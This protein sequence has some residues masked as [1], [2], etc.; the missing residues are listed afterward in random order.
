MW[1]HLGRMLLLVHAKPKQLYELVA[2]GGSAADRIRAARR[3]GENIVRTELSHAL[4]T[5]RRGNRR[6]LG[7]ACP[8]RLPAADRIGAAGGAVPGRARL[9][10]LTRRAAACAQSDLR[11]AA[12]RPGGADQE[13]A[14]GE[15]KEA[16]DDRD[17]RGSDRQ[18]GTSDR[19][20]ATTRDGPRRA[21][22]RAGS[23]C[24][25]FPLAD[26]IVRLVRRI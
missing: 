24:D 14:G 6:G 11:R 9:G 25:Q 22:H 13:A 12:A 23:V 7:D 21:D 1:L 20:C 5:R 8:Q 19:G 3:G 15:E 4:R 16:H 10:N 18:H 2:V 26:A 17:D